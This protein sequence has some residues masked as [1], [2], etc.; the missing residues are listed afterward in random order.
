VEFTPK[1]MTDD[2]WPYWEQEEEVFD[3]KC[4]ERAAKLTYQAEGR[5]GVRST[6]EVVAEL[7]AYMLVDAD[8]NFASL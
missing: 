8:R 4:A 2:Q 1:P 7:A 3:R 5:A 6:Q